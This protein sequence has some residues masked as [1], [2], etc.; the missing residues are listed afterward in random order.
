MAIKNF[1][2]L[3]L[4]L[5]S[6]TLISVAVAMDDPDDS[7]FNAKSNFSSSSA[8]IEK[9]K[10]PANLIQEGKQIIQEINNPNIRKIFTEAFEEISSNLRLQ[11]CTKDFLNL[12]KETSKKIV[13][14]INTND[15]EIQKTFKNPNCLSLLLYSF[16][17]VDEDKIAL[18]LSKID[19]HKQSHIVECF[20]SNPEFFSKF[21]DSIN[22]LEFLLI[23]EPSSLAALKDYPT[24]SEK[25]NQLC[26][27]NP[28]INQIF[29]SPVDAK[30]LVELLSKV[31]SESPTVLLEYIEGRIYPTGILNNLNKLQ[32]EQIKK[33]IKVLE[34]SKDNLKIKTI[35]S[36]L[37]AESSFAELLQKIEPEN[38]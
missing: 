35:L 6:S 23:F 4:S 14:Y 22:N 28:Q 29:S 11:I 25:L 32:N 10:L 15:M 20:L 21:S 30:S 1:L 18:E 9:G 5:L 34:K 7:S 31:K 27:N 12:I 26:K 24:E 36:F 3:T 19:H 2:T 33:L 13:D 37:I 16:G 17:K 8:Q 38:L